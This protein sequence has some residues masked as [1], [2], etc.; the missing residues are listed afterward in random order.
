[1]KTLSIFLL[2]PFL[3][4]AQT[5]QETIQQSFIN[6]YQLQILQ[7]EAEII[8]TQAKI[9][10]TWDDPIF[11]MG[12][13]DIQFEKPLSRD[14]EAMQNQYV[15]ISQKIPL[16][17]R[18]E[19]SSELQETKREVVEAQQSLLK[20]TIAFEVRKAFID[21]A[22]AQ[23]NLHVLDD[24]IAFLK[25]PMELL[26]NLSAVEKNSVEKYLKTE[27]LQKRYQIQRETWLR[28]IAIAKEQVELV[29]NIQIDTFEGEVILEEYHL[30]PLEGL[31]TQLENQSLQ[32]QVSKVLQ[33][34]AQKGVDLAS[35]KEQA[36]LTVTG[37]YYQRDARNDYVSLSLSYPL[38]IHDKQS[39]QKV[40]AMKRANIQHISYEQMKVQLQQQ[41]KII[42]HQLETLYQELALLRESRQK[43]TQLIANAKAELSS[44]GSLLRYYELFREKT[45]NRLEIQQKEY[46][47]QEQQNKIAQLL[48]VTL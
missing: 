46:R 4:Y 9:E 29:G 37:G 43:I 15:A 21:V 3:L 7:E 30:Q 10:G 42:K 16:S 5:V 11:K 36:D 32:L 47:I 40:Q 22:Y 38:Y 45:N 31:L 39:Q 26:E 44:S 18:L 25:T 8:G 35:A 17:N 20:S 27:L 34:V 33:S 48:G 41:L 24:Y 1:M 23:K 12:I 14:L 6:N 28:S 19:L 13:N 2:F